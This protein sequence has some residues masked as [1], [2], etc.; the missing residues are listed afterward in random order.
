MYL[1]VIQ[2]TFKLCL[3]C[4]PIHVV[5]INATKGV[6]S[7]HACGIILAVVM[8]AYPMEPASPFL[9]LHELPTDN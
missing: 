6:I 2:C 9:V 7:E 8:N 5:V 3:W 4:M 1:F